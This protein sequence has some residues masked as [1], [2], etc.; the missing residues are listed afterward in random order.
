MSQSIML[1][2][3]QFPSIS[4]AARFYGL[5]PGVLSYRLHAGWNDNEATHTKWEIKHG[6]A[7]K[8]HLG[9][10][11]RSFTELARHYGINPRNLCSRVYKYHWSLERALTTK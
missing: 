4:A 7:A 5:K 6:V 11:F 1:D 8:D 3:K 9:N 2:G 10:E